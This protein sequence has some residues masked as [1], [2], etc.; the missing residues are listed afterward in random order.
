[1]DVAIKGSLFIFFALIA[2]VNCDAVSS[3][4]RRILQFSPESSIQFEAQTPTSKPSGF[5]IC[6]SVSYT[7][8]DLRVVFDIVTPS[9]RHISLIL[10]DY[11]NDL[12][13]FNGELNFKYVDSFKL[14]PGTW[15]LICIVWNE[16]SETIDIQLN[17]NR[18]LNGPLP[19]NV[20]RFP[21]YF[22]NSTISITDGK[23]TDFNFWNRPISNEEMNNILNCNFEL[24]DQNK[25]EYVFWP[26]VKITLQTGNVTK[27]DSKSICQSESESDQKINLFF[28][29]QEPVVDCDRLNGA[30]P[31]A[32]SKTEIWKEEIFPGRCSYFW[33]PLTR[34]IVDPQKWLNQNTNTESSIDG[35]IY[36]VDKE[37]NCIVYGV[38]AKQYFQTSCKNSE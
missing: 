38:S 4:Y 7:T 24:S 14:F 1:M 29:S 28:T 3:S 16:T 27:S 34:S 19:L 2:I 17:G 26:E 18:V 32:T 12:G 20:R 10:S 21:K 33:L 37:K 5:T 6:L 35:L 11:M 15:N 25:P 22:S 30:M 36:D 23:M 13:T 8:W 31:S 9:H